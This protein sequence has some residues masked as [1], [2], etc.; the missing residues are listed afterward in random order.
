ME[1]LYVAYPVYL[2]EDFVTTRVGGSTVVIPWLVPITHKEA[3]LVSRQ[4][5]SKFEDLLV[6]SDPDL[7]DISR[8]SIA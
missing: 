8:T 5:W 1:A 4:G 2:P 7:V 6:K 3:G